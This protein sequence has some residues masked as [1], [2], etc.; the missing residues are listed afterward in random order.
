MGTSCA[1]GFDILNLARKV[2]V[3]GLLNAPL[4]LRATD[5]NNAAHLMF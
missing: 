1:T 2:V 4:A 5:S 3:S